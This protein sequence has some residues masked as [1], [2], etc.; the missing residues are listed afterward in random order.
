MLE[1]VCEITT[2]AI[3]SSIKSL[4][5]ERFL[6][7]LFCQRIAFDSDQFE[8]CESVSK[9]G[10]HSLLQ[11]S[12]ESLFRKAIPFLYFRLISVGFQPKI[13]NLCFGVFS[14]RKPKPGLF[15]L[16][17]LEISRLD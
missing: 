17:S 11:P 12:P 1:L 9:I 8:S 16:S 7:S 5:G 3:P 4:E 2:I 15:H 10:Y 14:L 6:N 13:A